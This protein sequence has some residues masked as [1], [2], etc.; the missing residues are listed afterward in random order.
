M[1]VQ[2]IGMWHAERL[3]LERWRL[4]FE[5]QNGQKLHF[6]V[7]SCDERAIFEIRTNLNRA[8]AIPDAARALIEGAAA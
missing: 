5:L 8:N 7:L 3:G 2:P 4:F 1:G 6:A